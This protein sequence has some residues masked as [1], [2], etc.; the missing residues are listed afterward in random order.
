MLEC[1]FGILYN[2]WRIFDCVVDVF[3]DFFDVIVLVPE[4]YFKF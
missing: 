2:K 1:A 4:F 3:A